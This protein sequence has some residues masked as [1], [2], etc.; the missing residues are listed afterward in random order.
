M[1]Q[2]P[3]SKWIFVILTFAFLLVGF[4]Q[5][6]PVQFPSANPMDFTTGRGKIHVVSHCDRTCASVESGVPA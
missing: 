4:A 2:Y 5:Q 6:A 3:F 1:K